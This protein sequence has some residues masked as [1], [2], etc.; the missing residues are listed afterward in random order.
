MS[1]MS[2]AARG[3]RIPL[4]ARISETVMNAGDRWRSHLAHAF[5]DIMCFWRKWFM[6]FKWTQG[7]VALSFVRIINSLKINQLQSVVKKYRNAFYRTVFRLHFEDEPGCH[8][9][10]V[11]Q[12]EAGLNAVPIYLQQPFYEYFVHGSHCTANNNNNNTK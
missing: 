8:L 11:I 9:R 7:T 1:K 5:C 12:T 3:K 4:F 10:F 2:V 6:G